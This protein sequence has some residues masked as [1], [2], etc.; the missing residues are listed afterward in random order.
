MFS[1]LSV[2]YY[3]FIRLLFIICNV[4]FT[5]S[6]SNRLSCMPQLLFMGVLPRIECLLYLY[7]K[8][9]TKVGRLLI[10][11][12][13]LSYDKNQ[14]KTQ[15]TN[16]KYIQLYTYELISR[17]LTLILNSPISTFD[18]ISISGCWV[19]PVQ[20]NENSCKCTCVQR[21]IAMSR[22]PCASHCALREAPL[23]PTAG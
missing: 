20:K 4:M 15:Y 2:L 18:D 5:S 3:H 23:V 16:N 10:Q 22:G 13:E 17:H 9:N 6:L 21:A 14:T 7:S 11:I 1:V 12:H 8:D 19:Y